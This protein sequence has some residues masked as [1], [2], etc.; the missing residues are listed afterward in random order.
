MKRKKVTIGDDALEEW[1]RSDQGFGA[2]IL[3][4]AKNQNSCQVL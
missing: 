4:G 1:N 3:A 2:R